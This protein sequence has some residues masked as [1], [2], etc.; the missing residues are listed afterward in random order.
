[1]RVK[2]AVARVRKV[3]GPVWAGGRCKNRAN[4]W[5]WQG[6]QTRVRL[7]HSH[8]LAERHL[9][10]EGKA[11]R[12]IG[13]RSG[14]GLFQIGGEQQR[15]AEWPRHDRDAAGR[16]AVSV[17]RKRERRGDPAEQYGEQLGSTAA[18]AGQLVEEQLSIPVGA[19]NALTCRPTNGQPAE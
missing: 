6:G 4:V 14:E 9:T 15:R 10:D 12:A 16:L 5:L 19:A 3:G 18:A 7:A 1:M 13:R 8:R 2:H 11:R 17:R